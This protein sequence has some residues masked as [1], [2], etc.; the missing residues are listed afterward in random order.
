MSSSNP[1]ST[2]DFH[3]LSSL[4]DEARLQAHLFKA[5]WHD[6][7]IDAERRWTQIEQELRAAAEHSR[8]ELGAATA[9]AADAVAESYRELLKAVR[10]H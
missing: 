6:R 1:L 8:R 4:R 5:E 7:W 10:A 2:V 3:H 9:L